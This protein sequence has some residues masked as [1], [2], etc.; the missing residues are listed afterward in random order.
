MTYNATDQKWTIDLGTTVTNAF[1]INGVITFY[2]KLIDE[3]GNA[4]G[5]MDPT[6]EDNTFAYTISN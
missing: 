5:S 6:G 2:I 4:F 1:I 3:A